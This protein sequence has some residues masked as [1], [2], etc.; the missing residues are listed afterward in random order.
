[1]HLFKISHSRGAI[2]DAMRCRKWLSRSRAST[3]YF[4]KLAEG[5]DHCRS[6][7]FTEKHA[8]YRYFSLSLLLRHYQNKL[9]IFRLLRKIRIF[10]L[11]K[12]SHFWLILFFFWLTSIVHHTSFCFYQIFVWGTIDLNDFLEITFLTSL[13]I[14]FFH[15]HLLL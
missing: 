1:M 6:C 10:F 14:K 8:T 12:L 2:D 3:L 11:I 5:F 7:C 15:W 4:F 13:S 9:Q